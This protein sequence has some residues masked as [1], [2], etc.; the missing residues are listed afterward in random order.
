MTCQICT[1]YASRRLP[2]VLAAWFAE[3]GRRVSIG[4]FMAGVHARHEAGLP[5]LT[6]ATR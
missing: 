3:T 4:R 6:E 1:E 5:V 2:V